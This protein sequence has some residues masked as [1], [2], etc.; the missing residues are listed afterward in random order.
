MSRPRLNRAML[1]SRIVKMPS[2][3]IFTFGETSFEYII[4]TPENDSRCLIR[5]GNLVSGKPAIV[6]PGSLVNSLEG[7][8]GEGVEAV[9]EFYGRLLEKLRVLGYRFE[10][11]P[12]KLSE[13][14]MPLKELTEK[15]LADESENDTAVVTSPPDLWAGALLKVSLEIVKASFSDNMTDLDERGYFLTET[16][17]N[18]RE[19]EILFEEA[20]ENRAY[21]GEL[22][23]KLRDYGL[24][25]EYE[26]RFFSL[27]NRG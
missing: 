12:E 26:D 15:I 19:I 17:R 24:F 5:R 10:N 11:R 21:L 3:Q 27:V 22:S 16:E 2:Q 7:F 25:E 20:A 13:A 23:D 9:K 18:R 4:L 8:E 6:T 1:L 14:G